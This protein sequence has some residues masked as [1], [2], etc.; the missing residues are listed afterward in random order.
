MSDT[1]RT[2]AA[3][4]EYQKS[5]WTNKAT[6]TLETVSIYFAKELERELNKLKELHKT[7]ITEC[8]QYTPEEWEAA[9]KYAEPCAVW[10]DGKQMTRLMKEKA[11]FA[12]LMP[13]II[14]Y[15]E[16]AEVVI[17]GEWG[18]CRELDQL[19]K[20][21]E[22]PEIYNEL[23]ELHNTAITE[24][25][26]AGSASMD[27]WGLTSAWIKAVKDRYAGCDLNDLTQIFMRGPFA[28][29]SERELLELANRMDEA[30]TV[31]P[32]WPNSED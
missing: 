7:A 8:T 32:I 9:C 11:R 18:R 15:I 1:P 22:M 30:Q 17:D 29:W 19:I 23:K 25:E 27:F 14:D 6:A 26:T 13:A 31:R 21:G 4:A 24:T 10:L 28:G 12:K 16:R 5:I 20:D 3:R 2:D